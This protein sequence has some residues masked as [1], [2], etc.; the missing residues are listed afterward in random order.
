MNGSGTPMNGARTPINFAGT[1]MGGSPMAVDAR[2]GIAEEERAAERAGGGG[3]VRYARRSLPAD[4]LRAEA[5]PPG[6]Q[7]ANKAPQVSAA[8]G[9]GWDGREAR[10]LASKV[11]ALPPR[12]ATVMGVVHASAL[13]PSVFFPFALLLSA[14][15]LPPSLR[16]SRPV[17]LSA[18][19]CCQ[20]PL[21]PSLLPL[22]C[23]LPPSLPLSSHA[24]ISFLSLWTASGLT[25]PACRSCSHKS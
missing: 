5:R 14:H 23:A 22:S 8:H 24:R 6:S 16:P 18:F 3:A 1:P 25:A 17:F 21:P 15:A 2:P 7:G 20:P 9:L 11:L 12:P 13:P 10:G 4:S 19:P